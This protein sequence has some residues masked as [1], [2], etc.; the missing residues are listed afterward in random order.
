M[1]RSLVGAL[2]VASCILPYCT[3]A[4]AGG[5]RSLPMHFAW[6]QEGPASVCGNQ[7]RTWISAIGTITADTPEAF[8]EFVR[9]RDAR[10]AVVALDSGGG[11]VHGAIAL[12]REIR[13]LGMT[14][15][16]GRTVLLASEGNVTAQ[17]ATLSPRADCESM[18]AFVLLA[19]V[20]RIVPREARVMVH[21]IWLGD[22]RDDAAAATYSADD[23]VLV[24]RDIGRLVQYTFEMGASADLLELSLRIP[25]WEPM[26][27]LSRA[28][29]QAMHVETEPEPL[30][31]PAQV[32]AA[33]PAE[34][35]AA[36]NGERRSPESARGWLIVDEGGRPELVRR[37]ILTVEG[38]EIGSFDLTLACGTTPDAFAI[39]YSERRRVDDG[40][41]TPLK[42]VALSLGAQSEQLELVSSTPQPRA[43]ELSSVA[44][45]TISAKLMQWLSD[46]ASHAVTVSTLNAKN[47]RT[48]IRVGNSGLGPAL[49]KLKESCGAG[50]PPV[51]GKQAQLTPAPSPHR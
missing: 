49:A 16:I 7:C 11:S 34:S 5:P 17:R 28:E 23:L 48:V 4:N 9:N 14:T 38:V 37:H 21:Q 35:A 39:S 18:C 12:G 2:A 25:P 32:V 22:R 45:G 33:A 40:T 46:T 44:R 13:R 3:D 41:M 29:M 6:Q 20:K 47:A 36:T 42:T 8:T 24:Q 1:N 50:H 30:V 10:G 19:G 26:H 31:S 43:P 27:S 51:T 15:T